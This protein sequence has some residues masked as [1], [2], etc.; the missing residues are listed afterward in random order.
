MKTLGGIG[1]RKM[2]E[3]VFFCVWVVVPGR[4]AQ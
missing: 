2:G 1:K 3:W 4:R